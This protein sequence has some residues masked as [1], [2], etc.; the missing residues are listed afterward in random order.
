MARGSTRR[1]YVRDGRGRFAST[2]T[3]GTKAKPAARR[4]QRG[5]NRITRDNSGKIT[6]VGKNGTTARGGRLRTAA[7]NQRGA[8]LDRLKRAPMAGAMRGRAQRDPGAM[9]K[10]GKGLA[11]PPAKPAA[12]R[13]TKPAKQ[14]KAAA[15][16][17]A[18]KGRS[19][20]VA[21]TE[22]I[23]QR[24]IAPESRRGGFDRKGSVKAR[25]FK[26]TRVRAL[27]YIAKAAGGTNIKANGYKVSA[28]Y[29]NQTRDQMVQSVANKLSKPTR[30]ST[31]KNNSKVVAERQKIRKEAA[32]R[33]ADYRSGKGVYGMHGRTVQAGRKGT[34]RVIP[35]SPARAKGQG[36]VYGN[37][38]GTIWTGRKVFR[39]RAQAARAQAA[40]KVAVGRLAGTARLGGPISGIRRGKAS[41]PTLTG[42]RATT[43]GRMRFA[44]AGRVRAPRKPAK[45]AA[46]ARVQNKAQWLEAMKKPQ[47]RRELWIKS[48]GAASKYKGAWNMPGFAKAKPSRAGT[49]SKPKGYKSPVRQAAAVA[50]GRIKRT[51]KQAAAAYR[52]R[53]A[54]MVS[55]TRWG[56]GTMD[57]HKLR[58]I[59]MGQQLALIGRPKA[60]KRYQRIK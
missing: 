10:V 44:S 27:K 49:I 21:K 29:G 59:V 3:T 43:Y 7:G 6:G 24:V 11:K 60:I 56:M 26:E 14:P 46:P 48:Y 17:P 25:N 2:G 57:P 51:R 18:P 47:S 22:R 15:A 45:P 54:R 30:R 50:S 9:G 58:T 40:R 32:Q 55:N 41:Q 42:G 33:A 16:K 37:G 52:R 4:A 39:T 20:D 34:L 13:P 1:S 19:V 28:D 38:Y 8:V 36:P 23:L 12:A 53:N 5:T 35:A 31:L